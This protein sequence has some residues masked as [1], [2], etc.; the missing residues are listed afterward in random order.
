V[1]SAEFDGDPRLVELAESSDM[2]LKK[3]VFDVMRDVARDE[4][5]MALS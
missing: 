2:A 5:L 3:V 4:Q 1:F